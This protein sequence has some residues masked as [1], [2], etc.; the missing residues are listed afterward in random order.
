M[1]GNTGQALVIVDADGNYYVLPREVVQTAKADP[2]SRAAIEQHLD[3][4]DPVPLAGGYS[5]AGVLRLPPGSELAHYS[6]EPC[7]PVATTG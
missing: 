3:G 1:D 6:P 4:H 7:W 2:A 5:F